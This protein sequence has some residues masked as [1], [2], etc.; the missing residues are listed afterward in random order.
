M[1]FLKDSLLPLEAEF[2]SIDVA[3]VTFFEGWGKGHAEN[4][5]LLHFLKVYYIFLNIERGKN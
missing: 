1:S 4:F 3:A 5:V 2:N